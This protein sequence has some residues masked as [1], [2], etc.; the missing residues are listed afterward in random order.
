M[1]ITGERTVPG[2]EHENY[3]FRRHE[4]VYEWLLAY[5]SGARVLEAGAGEGYGAGLMSRLAAS[6]VALDFDATPQPPIRACRRSGG[7]SSGC[8]SPTHRS[9]SS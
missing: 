1:E 9:T 2:V 3:W 4:V 7:T 8:R 6:V 5:V